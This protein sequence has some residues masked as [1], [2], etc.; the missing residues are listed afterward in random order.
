MLSEATSDMHKL[1]GKC[2]HLFRNDGS[3]IRRHS[4][5]LKLKPEKNPVYQKAR[6]VTYALM[7]FV[8]N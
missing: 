8:E 1:M 5:T 4:A 3:T 6:P 2:A 7:D